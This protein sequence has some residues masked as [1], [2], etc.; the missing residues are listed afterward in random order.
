MP[1]LDSSSEIPATR[2]NYSTG[3]TFW[4]VECALTY[5]SRMHFKAA[6]INILPIDDGSNKCVTLSSAEL[7]SVFQ[8]VVLVQA[9]CSDQPGVRQWQAGVFS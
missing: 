7:L 2:S 9:H 3:G 8:L 1:C 6:P 4:N 5:S